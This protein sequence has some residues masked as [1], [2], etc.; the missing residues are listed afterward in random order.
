MHL[1][2]KK[3]QA[4]TEDIRVMKLLRQIQKDTIFAIRLKGMKKGRIVLS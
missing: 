4:L 3:S 1:S 2:V